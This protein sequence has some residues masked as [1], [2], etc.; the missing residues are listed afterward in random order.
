MSTRWYRLSP[1]RVVLG[2]LVMECVLWL[3]ER[4]QWFGFNLHKG[5]TV[6]IAVAVVGVAMLLMLGWFVVALFFRWRFQFSIRSLLVL[7]VAVAVPFSWIAVEVQQAKRY[8]DAVTAITKAEGLVYYDFQVDQTGV[9]IPAA[10]IPGPIWLRMLLGD[11]FFGSVVRVD[12]NCHGTDAILAKVEELP[13]IRE[14]YVGS[15]LSDRKITD[16]GLEHVSRMAGLQTLGLGGTHVTDSGIKK[17]Q[18]ALPHCDIE[19]Y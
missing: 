14:L 5:W 18:T 3:S 9:L 15:Y 10:K 12:F 6:L 13:Q 1:D 11:D 7:T 16:A 8:R 2:L 17:L 19:R 4:F